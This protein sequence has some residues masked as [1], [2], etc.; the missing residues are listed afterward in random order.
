MLMVASVL[1]RE[2]GRV[3]ADKPRRSG[4]AGARLLTKI[5]KT[6]KGIDKAIARGISADLFYEDEDERLFKFIVEH[7]EEYGRQPS[8]AL[9]EEHFADYPFDERGSQDSL[10]FLLEHFLEKAA[11][12]LAFE[13]AEATVKEA[14]SNKPV[15]KRRPL[16]VAR[17]KLDEIEELLASGG[18]GGESIPS[19]RIP[20]EGGQ[21]TDP[22]FTHEQFVRCATEADQMLATMRDDFVRFLF[23]PDTRVY[24]LLAVWCLH[25]WPWEAWRATPYLDFRSP[26]PNSGKTTALEMLSLYSR[27][28]WFTSGGTSA[29]FIDT[30]C[31]GAT[32]VLDELDENSRR[33][34]DFTATLYGFLNSGY[35]PSGNWPVREPN[36]DGRGWVTVMRSTF[37]PKAF[38][39][40]G[41]N[42]APATQTRC[43]TINMERQESGKKCAEWFGLG[44]EAE[45][46]AA[47][48]REYLLHGDQ[49]DV[50]RVKHEDGTVTDQRVKWTEV[51]VPFLRHFD[52]G[53]AL[54]ALDGRRR[55]IFTPLLAVAHFASLYGETDWTEPILSLAFET[56]DDYEDREDAEQLIYDCRSIFNKARVD[57]L[58]SKRLIRALSAIDTSPWSQYS[59]PRGRDRLSSRDLAKLLSRFKIRPKDVH[60]KDDEGIRRT[61]SGYKRKDFENAWKRYL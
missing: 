40:I 58:G 37:G 39:G 22:R 54:D 36:P 18:D 42:L 35:I 52:R 45:A 53:E 44:E 5:A 17:R 6:G 14:H 23:I 31:N 20:V 4:N 13:L 11:Q 21:V 15:G 32:L 3:S 48:V 56:P 10:D 51:A 43:I 41:Q 47:P 19:R 57:E 26:L 7:T 59:G 28:G 9:L 30:V 49:N 38:A 25:T 12:V 8:I 46:H 16:E 60:E 55:Q 27:Q 29:T 33:E 34:G 24:M 1:A 50:V 61:V 2:G